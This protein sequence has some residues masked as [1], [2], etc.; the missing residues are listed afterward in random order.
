LFLVIIDLSNCSNFP[1][2]WNEYVITIFQIK[3]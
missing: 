1:S 3:K 2:Q